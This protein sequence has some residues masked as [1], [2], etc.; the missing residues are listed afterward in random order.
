MCSLLSI[1]TYV[2]VL[3]HLDGV[4]GFPIFDWPDDTLVVIAAPLVA[5][6]HVRS[7]AV[8]WW[9]WRRGRLLLVRLGRNGRNGT[10]GSLLHVLCV[11]VRV[12]GE[13]VI[14]VRALALEPGAL[15]FRL[16]CRFQQRVEARL[17]HGKQRLLVRAKAQQLLVVAFIQHMLGEIR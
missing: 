15:A 3:L 11:R 1:T 17:A 5:P 6:N 16:V 4:D 9:G 14:I 7:H 8:A 12:G 10:G 13:V 2:R